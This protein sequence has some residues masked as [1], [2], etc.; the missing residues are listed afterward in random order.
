M[1][2][3]IAITNYSQM[4]NLWN[5]MAHPPPSSITSALDH[6]FIDSD[7]SSDKGPPLL[8]YEDSSR[9]IIILFI[10][11]DCY[12]ICTS[13][14]RLA[15]R[16]YLL[17]INLINFIDLWLITC[18]SLIDWHFKLQNCVTEFCPLRGNLIIDD[19]L[20]HV[21]SICHREVFLKVKEIVVGQFSR[22]INFYSAERPLLFP[23]VF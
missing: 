21:Y 22:G 17:L 12:T 9:L 16:F 13:V 8:C 4:M 19:I 14:L 11:L 3:Q 7:K 20:I 10:D 18:L 23:G 2:A 1:G 15:G 6:L 5:L